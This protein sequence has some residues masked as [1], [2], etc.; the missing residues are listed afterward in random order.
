M[1]DSP[2]PTRDDQHDDTAETA[3]M[4]NS[5]MNETDAAGTTGGETSGEFSSSDSSADGNDSSGVG[6]A[7]LSERIGEFQILRRLGKGGMGEVYLAEQTSLKRQV[8]LKVMRSKAVNDDEKHLERFKTEAMAAAHLN[9]PNIV[10]VYLIGEEDGC[11]FIAQEYVQGKNLR[12]FISRKGP[13]ELPIALHIIKQAATA[14]KKAGDAGIVHRD[15]KPENLMITRK[16]VVKIAD[17]GLARLSQGGQNVNL[18]QVGM[19]MGTPTYMSPEQ[20]HGDSVD[21]RSDIYSLGVTCYHML[22]GRPPFRGETA[23]AVAVKH[24]KDEA[25]Q[26]S[27]ARPDL[28]KSVC[29]M[30]HKMMAKKPQKRYQD[31]AE[32]LEDIKKIQ[33]ATQKGEDVKIHV[34]EFVDE[35]VERKKRKSKPVSWHLSVTR[36]VLAC[37]AM[38]AVGAG[39]G[40][41]MRT[42]NLLR[43]KPRKQSEQPLATIQQQYDK[44]RILAND[45]TAWMDVIHHPDNSRV[46]KDRAKE[47]LAL[48]YLQSRRFDEAGK[49]FQDFTSRGILHKDLLAKGLAGQAVIASLEGDVNKSHNLISLQLKQVSD[50][51]NGTL[52]EL[53]L[54]TIARNRETLGDQVKPSLEDYFAEDPGDETDDPAEES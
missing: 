51:L 46:E 5:G 11:H 36:F 44:A 7:T 53:V 54:D 32:I 45:E 30:V 38:L 29:D 1:T 28:P 47:Q 16:G 13:P 9:H 35:P 17:F 27:L 50:K 48:I 43:E 8:A 14:L 33:A 39:V 42:E 21:P 25:P 10:Q 19:T 26:L 18:T 40:W 37:L 6:E 41:A 15:I 23:L 12:E 4:P 24:I 20:V 2:N 3:A 34:E 49:I 52:R 22:A 31:A